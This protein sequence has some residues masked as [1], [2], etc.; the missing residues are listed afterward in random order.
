MPYTRK[1]EAAHM[2]YVRN[3]DAEAAK[4]VEAALEEGKLVDW[5]SSTF[6]DP[7]VDWNHLRVDGVV[8]FRE[9][10]Y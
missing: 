1:F 10:G 3:R 6:S 7:G 5:E 8:V 4:K 2:E 9:S